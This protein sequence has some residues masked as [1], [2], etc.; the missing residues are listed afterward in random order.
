[1]RFLS[2]KEKKQLENSLP[3]GYYI[4]KK[5]EI[6]E[7]KSPPILYKGEEPFLIIKEKKYLPHLKSIPESEYKSVYVDKGA[8]PFILKGA[9][10]MRPGIRKIDENFAKGEIIMIKD[11]THK[12]TIALGF[13]LLSSE[14]MQKQDKGKSVEIYHFVSDEYY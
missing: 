6:K 8:I 4:D 13:V 3:K 14:E 10:L 7:S 1:M 12:K 9:D 2:N 11:E 5:E